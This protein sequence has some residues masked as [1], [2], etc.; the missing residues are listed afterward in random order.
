MIRILALIPLLLFINTSY[1]AQH[2]TDLQKKAAIFLI[3]NSAFQE[4]VGK[5]SMARNACNPTSPSADCIN[6]V[7][8]SYPSS[9]E[10]LA[11]ARAC[12]GV[13]SVD[14]VKFIAGSYPSF[15]ERVKAASACKN[16]VNLDCVQFVAGSYP[17]FD[18]RTKAGLAC[19][20]ADVNCVKSVVG[21]Y[22]NFNERV[23]AAQACGGK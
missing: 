7:A 19:E 8:G 11:A 13:S 20:N 3:E 5:N 15:D 14:C 18:E 4:T 2:L 23:K 9:D 12:T 6:F 10:K 22:P 21:S 16:N 17:S 1:A